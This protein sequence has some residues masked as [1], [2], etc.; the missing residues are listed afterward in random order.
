MIKFLRF[1]ILTASL[2]PMILAS[3]AIFQG[4]APTL[5]DRLPRDTDVPG[6]TQADRGVFSGPESL[7]FI[8]GNYLVYGV[9]EVAFSRYLSV[10]SSDIILDVIIARTD[11]ILNSFGLF[12][13]ERGFITA[14]TMKEDSYSNDSGLFFRIGQYYVKVLTAN[15]EDVR[16]DDLKMFR[17][18]IEPRLK[19]DAAK[20]GLP[21]W[22]NTLSQSKSTD[23]VFYRNGSPL[24]PELKDL[25]VRKKIIEDRDV[26]LFFH[27]ESS[28]QGA[29]GL[30]L[31]AMKN[32]SPGFTLSKS[33]PLKYAYKENPEGGYFFITCR[34]EWIYGVM[35][36]ESVSM[37]GR[38]MV[39]LHSELSGL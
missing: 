37:G 2:A 10:S 12:S 7:S 32:S 5:A 21:V 22:L 28:P 16:K 13:L 23:I 38:I 14:R 8:S 15:V 30:L 9:S 26:Y 1:K 11:S 24:M 17:D 34:D 19:T 3:C 31:S 4:G 25:F 29:A 20:G 18:V 39:T 33:G 27:K 6:W 36:A 35:N